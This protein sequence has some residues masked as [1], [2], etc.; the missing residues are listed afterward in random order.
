MTTTT[1][2]L[3]DELKARVA[4]AAERCGK[5]P[6]AFI[7]EAI[8]QTVEASESAAA[9]RQLAE[10]RWTRLLETG[11][12][13]PFEQAKAYLEARAAG[14]PAARPASKRPR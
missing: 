12:S 8:E 13:V 3:E 7:L 9:F 11:K 14:T 2:R 6:H 10:T 5:S 1:I 4:A